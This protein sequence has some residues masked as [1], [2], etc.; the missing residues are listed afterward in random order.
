[1]IHDLWRQLKQ[2]PGAE[3]SIDL[4]NQ[5][6]TARTAAHNAFEISPLRK[7]RLV[8]GIDDVD[9]TLA[10]R[11]AIRDLR[12]QMQDG[13]SLASG[14]RIADR[15]RQDGRESRRT[16]MGGWMLGNPVRAKL[17]KGGV[18][19]GHMRSSSSA[20]REPDHGQCRLRV[21]QSS[22]PS[23]PAPASRP[24]RLRYPTHAAP[25]SCR[26]CAYG[27]ALPPDR[28]DAR[29]R[30]AGHQ[31]PMSRAPSRPRY[32]EVVPLSPRGRARARVR[33][34]HD[35]YAGGDHIAAMKAANERTW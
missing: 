13:T 3:I 10:Y 2:N 1:V 30:R 23:I 25:A 7:E 11:D 12:R 20:G 6:V 4:P 28:A 5:R 33:M 29:C 31:V 14:S 18:A 35:D 19:L 24:S 15:S 32:R 34:A 16:R 21:L 8:G 17:R 27:L 26:W 9:V 22:T